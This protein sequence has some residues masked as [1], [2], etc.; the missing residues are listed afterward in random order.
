V[1]RRSFGGDYRVLTS[2]VGVHSAGRVFLHFGGWFGCSA[3]GFDVRHRESA[4]GGGV[5]AH[6]TC[7]CRQEPQTAR[8]RQLTKPQTAVYSGETLC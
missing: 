4:R 3:R 2:S 1:R 7:S 6:G 5:D 8:L